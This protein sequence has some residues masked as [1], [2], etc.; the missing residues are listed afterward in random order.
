MHRVNDLS[1]TGVRVVRDQREIERLRWFQL[2]R[3]FENGLISE[4]PR[5]LPHDPAVVDSTYF[6][7]Y[8]ATGHIEASARL[9]G[10]QAEL[11]MLGYEL[12]PE[13]A[14]A[15][16]S[17]RDKLAEVSRL[18]VA[19][20]G[21]NHQALGLMARELFHYCL[22][23][24]EA[25]ALVASIE[26]PMIRILDQVLGIPVEVIGPEIPH[27][28]NFHGTCLPVLIDTV[29]YLNEARWRDHRRWEFF[30]DDLV[31]DLTDD[32]PAM[33]VQPSDVGVAAGALRPR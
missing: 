17:R 26:K 28:Q 21:P 8:S 16:F 18:A 11:P 3:Y 2:R 25:T 14:D 19:R 33:P 4:L 29:R 23:H 9:I 7:V 31:I 15:L 1:K 22:R 10:P 5:S 32:T 24:Q 6:G 20:R 12:F 30:T 13:A 27:Y